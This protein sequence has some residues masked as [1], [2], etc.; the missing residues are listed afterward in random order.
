MNELKRL[1]TVKHTEMT[2]KQKNQ[3]KKGTSTAAAKPAVKLGTAGKAF[4]KSSAP[5][6]DDF[7][8]DYDDD[9]G[10]FM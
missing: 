2:N 1:V 4:V 3:K 8:G 10:D 5:Y 7:G 6:G 9:D